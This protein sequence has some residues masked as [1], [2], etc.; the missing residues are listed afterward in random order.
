MKS[1]TEPLNRSDS[2]I[3]VPSDL[4]F[5][6]EIDDMKLRT[7][8]ALFLIVVS[9]CAFGWTVLGQRQGSTPTQW[10]YTVKHTSTIEQTPADFSELGAQGWE[11]VNVTDEGWGYFKRQKR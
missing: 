11:L 1:Q 8:L 3:S 9:I 2:I 4:F 7:S 10:E 6:K 5:P